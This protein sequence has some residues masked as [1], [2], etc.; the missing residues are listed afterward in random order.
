MVGVSIVPVPVYTVV[1]D[2]RG[3]AEESFTL[4]YLYLRRQFINTRLLVADSLPK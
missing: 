3:F 2:V 4:G 1:A